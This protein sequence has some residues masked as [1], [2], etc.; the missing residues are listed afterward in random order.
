MASK[1]NAPSSQELR[2][3]RQYLREK[4]R[5]NFYKTL[6]R[7]LCVFGLA[8]G[9]V[10]LA[11]SPIWNVRSAEQIAVSD[12][13][14]LADENVQAL[15]PIPYPQSLLSVEP[16]LL[17]ESLEAYEPIESA[18]VSRRLIPP[19]LHVRIRERQPVAVVLPNSAQ[20]LSSSS[21]K[22]PIPFEEPGLID[23]K[24]YWMPR[25][26]FQK[27]GVDEATNKAVAPGLVIRGMQAKHESQWRSMY[28]LIQSSP[29][30]ITAID[31]TKPSD[32]ILQSEL[33]EVRVGPYGSEFK[34]QL[35]AL[36]QIRN[37]RTKVNPEQVAYIDLQDPDNPIIQVFQATSGA[38][39]EP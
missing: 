38:V 3:R 37:L 31:W 21:D 12:N 30:T 16:Q 26:S 6:W 25:N 1:R 27:L 24:G 28:P 13:Q 35:A 7:S 5:R 36:D 23:A 11:T 17:V 34:A 8:T 33:G 10:W 9:S 14:L 2:R 4:R 22:Q 20:P 39:S 18:T 15:L 29:V 32:L 19:S